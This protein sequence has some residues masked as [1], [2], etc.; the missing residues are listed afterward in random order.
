VTNKLFLVPGA[1]TLFAGLTVLVLAACGRPTSDTTGAAGQ[2]SNSAGSSAHAG[3]ARPLPGSVPSGPSSNPAVCPYDGVPITIRP[4]PGAQPGPICLHPGDAVTLN[5][6]PSPLQPW[7]PPTSS[8]PDTLACT[9]Q[10]LGNGALTATCHALRPGTAT[11]S[12]TTAPFAGGPQGI[13]QWIRTLTIHVTPA[14]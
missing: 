3:T 12:T 10:P 4:E 7:Q 14:P 8:D 13:P 2:Q 5:A 11:V 6:Q 1:V 9:S